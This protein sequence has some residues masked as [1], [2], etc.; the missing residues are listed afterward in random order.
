MGWAPGE[1]ERAVTRRQVILEAMSGKISWGAA[2]SGVGRVG[3]HAGHGRKAILR[4]RNRQ[5]AGSIPAAP[6]SKCR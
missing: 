5:M 4:I 1:K 2:P 6:W 3:T